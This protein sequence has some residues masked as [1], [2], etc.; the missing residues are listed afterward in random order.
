MKT[1]RR[2]AHTFQIFHGKPAKM[3]RRRCWISGARKKGITLLG[4]GRYDTS[5]LA[6]GAEDKLIPAEQGLFG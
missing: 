3:A 5:H 4:T 6:A 1:D 2:P